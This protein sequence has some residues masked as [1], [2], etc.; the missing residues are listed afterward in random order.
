MDVV[1]LEL[2]VMRLEFFLQMGEHMKEVGSN[3]YSMG[4]LLEKESLAGIEAYD[5][6]MGSLADEMVNVVQ[7]CKTQLRSLLEYL[8][9]QVED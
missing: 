4:D 7:T 9:E 8:E 5:E 3:M 1:E 6:N 2:N